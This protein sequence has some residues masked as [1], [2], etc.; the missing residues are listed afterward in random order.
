MILVGF[1]G[2]SAIGACDCEWNVDYDLN[3]A[4]GDTILV[5]AINIYHDETEITI[6]ISVSDPYW[7]A[8]AQVDVAYSWDEDLNVPNL[9]HTKKGSPKIGQYQS[10]ITYSPYVQNSKHVI[11]WDDVIGAPLEPDWCTEYYIGV[12][13]VI[14][15]KSNGCYVNGQTGWG[16]GEDWPKSWGMWLVYKPCPPGKILKVETTAVEHFKVTRSGWTKSYYKVSLDYK[17]G[18][19]PLP[20]YIE[21]QSGE[22]YSY[23]GWC[24]DKWG[25][26]YTGTEYPRKGGPIEL[27]STLDPDEFPDDEYD[28]PSL[29]DR[30]DKANWEA[31]NYVLNHDDAYSAGVIQNVIWVF[32]KNLNP[33]SPGTSP[34]YLLYKDTIDNYEDWSPDPGDWVGVIVY[35]KEGFNCPAPGVQLL[36]IEVDP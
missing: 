20:D 17:D 12:H 30:F 13:V 36:I 27:Y 16:D 26:I 3:I 14:Y 35:M 1:S 28:D 9:P 31:I 22:W 34:F 10:S 29:G 5:D 23:T 33:P 15:E 6:T 2:I 24:V 4:N 19:K 18:Y 21:P 11:D 8:E 25:K 7:L 32:T